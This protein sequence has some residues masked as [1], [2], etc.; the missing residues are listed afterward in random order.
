MQFTNTSFLTCI[1]NAESVPDFTVLPSSQDIDLK[2]DFVEVTLLCSA[3]GASSYEWQ[4]QG[5]DIPTTA[6]GMNTNVLTFF[7]LDPK[8]AGNYQCKA[9]NDHGC[10]SSD[11]AT[12]NITGNVD[13]LQF[14][15]FQ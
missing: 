12:I 8:T 6:T 14:C 7:T 1:G 2:S 15:E 11:Y 3:H 9:C 5:S 10:V 13:A 4:R